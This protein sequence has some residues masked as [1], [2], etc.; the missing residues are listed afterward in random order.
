[1]RSLV[2][3]ASCILFSAAIPHQGG[4]SHLNEQWPSYWTR[5]FAEHSFRPW[6]LFRR[7]IWNEE[8]VE[9]WYAQN[10]LLFLRE[11]EESK[12]PCLRKAPEEYAAKRLDVVH[13]RHYLRTIH[14]KQSI[15]KALWNC[16]AELVKIDVENQ[17]PRGAILILADDGTLALSTNKLASVVRLC[18]IDGT[19]QGPPP[20]SRTAIQR[21]ERLRQLRGRFLVLT[22]QVFWW[23][24]YFA[25]LA[26][27]LKREAVCLLRNDRC[28]IYQFV[29]KP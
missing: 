15:E 2:R 5:L 12:Y 17:V 11:G 22:W 7:E 14:E 16:R 1:M 25:G 27:Y 24:T 19:Y 28:R 3:H 8:E 10:M 23:E 9:Y 26:S 13:P 20:D 6:D 4:K 29:D 21:I 18:E